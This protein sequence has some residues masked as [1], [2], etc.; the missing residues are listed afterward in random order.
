VVSVEAVVAVVGQLTVTIGED[1]AVIEG[2][3]AAGSVAELPADPEAV[4]AHVRFDA[5]GRYRP[6]PGSLDL[7]G[8]WRARFE[9]LEDLDAAIDAVYPLG[10]IHAAQWADGTLR[11]VSLEEVLA[12]QSGRY[13]SSSGLSDAGRERAS[14]VLCSQCARTPVWPFRAA[15]GRPQGP[16]PLSLPCPEPCS[17]LVSLCREAAAWEADAPPSSEPDAAVPFAAFETPGNAIREAL[18]PLLEHRR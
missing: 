11:V 10:T 17:V 8:G 14:A 18:I 4:R 6:L 9:R 13:E 7:P 12:R 2:P 3:P 16:E 5:A 1:E 15:D